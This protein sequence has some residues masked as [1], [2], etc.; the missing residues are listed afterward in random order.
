MNRRS[1]SGISW[2]SLKGEER[3]GIRNMMRE[4]IIHGQAEWYI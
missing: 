3:C 4:E 1:V 2:G